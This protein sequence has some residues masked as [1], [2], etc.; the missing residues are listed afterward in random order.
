MRRARHARGSTRISERIAEALFRERLPALADDK[1]EVAAR[2]HRERF[3]EDRQHRDNGGHR[4]PALFRFHP[5]NAVVNMLAAVSDGVAAAQSAIEQ[6]VEPYALFRPDRPV[7]LVCR[8]V[9]LGPWKEAIALRSRRIIDAGSRIGIGVPRLYRPSEQAAHG[10]E[11]VSRLM[12]RA[13][14]SLAAGDDRIRAVI[15]ANGVEPA[16]AS[17][18][19]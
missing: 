2:P 14:A 19:L 13:G 15:L 3:G 8:D 16:R 17:T 4:E 5:A 6:H 12:R 11:E 7:P 10:V 9:L 18:C 1:R